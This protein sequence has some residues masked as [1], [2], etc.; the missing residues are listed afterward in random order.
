MTT[1]P[2][3][4]AL[5]KSFEQCRLV[6]YLPTPHDVPTIGWGHTDSVKMGDTCTQE[7]ADEYLEEDLRTSE[8]AI[9]CKV[10]VP[11]TQNQ[12]DAMVSF[13]FNV[14]TGN[15]ESSTLLHMLNLGQYNTAADQFLRWDKQAGQ[16]LPGLLSR[17]QAERALFLTQ[18]GV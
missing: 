9:E 18:E 10:S 1:S 8:L 4:I 14:G 2:A 16:V 6:A 3:G 13:V 15:F 7:Q 5:I 12:F 11:L 17:R